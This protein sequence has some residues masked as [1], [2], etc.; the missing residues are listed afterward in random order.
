M[1]HVFLICML[2]LIGMS[3][4]RNTGDSKF[5]ILDIAQVAEKNDSIIF[6]GWDTIKGKTIFIGDGDDHINMIFL[7][8]SDSYLIIMDNGQFFHQD[9]MDRLSAKTFQPARKLW[10]HW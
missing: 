10:R 6:D 3:C 5:K 7:T 1:K 9:I 2:I 4:S 8:G